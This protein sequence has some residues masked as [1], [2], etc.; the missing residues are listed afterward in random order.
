MATKAKRKMEKSQL[1][2]SRRPTIARVSAWN[3]NLKNII[4]IKE[5]R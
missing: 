5:A 4:S 3:R 2:N 1:W